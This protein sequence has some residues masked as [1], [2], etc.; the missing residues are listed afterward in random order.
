MGRETA[1]LSTPKEKGK[2]MTEIKVSMII[3]TE[4]PERLKSLLEHHIEQIVDM[5]SDNLISTIYNVQ[6]EKIN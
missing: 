1:P 6:A 5:E 2:K 3:E 4:E